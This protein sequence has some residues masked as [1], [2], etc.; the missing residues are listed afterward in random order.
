MLS[1][2]STSLS[3]FFLLMSEDDS[4]KR[5]QHTDA[6]SSWLVSYG[7][8]LLLAPFDCHHYIYV[9]RGGEGRGN[10]GASIILLCFIKQYID[11]M[12]EGFSKHIVHP[13]TRN[14]RV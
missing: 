6:S 8:Q 1:S 9:T 13:N 4:E 3:Q 10:A 5:I 14:L 2:V 11:N 12:F 7:D